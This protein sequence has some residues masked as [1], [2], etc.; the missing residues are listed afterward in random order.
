MVPGIGSE[1][2]GIEDAL[3]HFFLPSLFG[4]NYDDDDPRRDL[5]C[6]PVKWAGMAIPDP[7]SS[8][9]SNYEASTLLCSHIVSAFKGND[10]FHSAN[11]TSMTK[12]VKAVLKLR[13]AAKFEAR[14]DSLASELPCDSRR[15]ILRGKSTGQWL[16][17]PPSTVNG[18]ELA[19]QEFRD[20][21][22]L[23]YARSPPDL[24]SHI[25]L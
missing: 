17:V 12:E 23:R 16:S 19:K 4:D 15:T 10:K 14:L 1:F 22:L 21:L 7:T 20:A 9:E 8:A 2:I 24:P 5:S 3:S 11:H 25:T 18:T 6:L 13:N